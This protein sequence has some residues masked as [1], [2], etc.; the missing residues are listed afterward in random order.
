MTAPHL[1]PKDSQLQLH[2]NTTSAL[3]QRERC[4][5]SSFTTY[6]QADLF[7][8]PTVPACSLGQD[9]P[10]FNESEASRA[11]R[12]LPAPLQSGIAA[13]ISE[14]PQRAP[15]EGCSCCQRPAMESRLLWSSRT[16]LCVVHAFLHRNSCQ[17]LMQFGCAWLE[18]TAICRPAGQMGSSL[19]TDRHL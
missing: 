14:T 10:C 9:K 11:H 13:Q 4:T 12:G 1:P 16:C 19:I 5:Q 15:L 6:G 7:P 2:P 17:L 18:E 3:L 8:F